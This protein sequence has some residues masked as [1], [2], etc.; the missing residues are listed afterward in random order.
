MKTKITS[1]AIMSVA[2]ILAGVVRQTHADIITWHYEDDFS[3]EKAKNDSY[4]HSGFW[5][6]VALPPPHPYLY[7]TEV[8][9]PADMLGFA[10][11]YTE[12]AFLEY[13]FPLD[14]VLTRVDSGIFELDVILGEDLC[15]LLYQ[16]SVDGVGWT[17]TI[18]LVEGY[19]QISL[20]PSNNP[21]TYIRLSANAARIDN[22]SVSVVGPEIPEPSTM[23]LLCAGM[24]GIIFKKRERTKI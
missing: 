19:N 14:S 16:L 17:E 4:D 11:Y 3:T 18:Q 9:T 23:A 13:C 5:P 7:Y 21:Y 24:I 2:L 15:Y 20:L 22:L 8:I 6:E 10:G 1:I 12:V